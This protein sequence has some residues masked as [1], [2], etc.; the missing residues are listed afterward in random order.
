M[1]LANNT[2][3]KDQRRSAARQASTEQADAE[4]EA[5]N[6]FVKVDDEASILEVPT[7]VKVVDEPPDL[8][9][10]W[11]HEHSSKSSWQVH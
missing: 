8:F 1:D 5:A 11:I 4:K 9:F 2:K 6:A 10:I 7:H 3:G